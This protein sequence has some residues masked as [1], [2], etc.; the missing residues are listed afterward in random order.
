MSAGICIGF[1]FGIPRA[2]TVEDEDGKRRYGVNTNLEQI[3]DWLTKIIVGVSLIQLRA[4]PGYVSR[5][6]QRLGPSFGGD[7]GFVLSILVGYSVCG[8]LVGYLLT[9]LYM[10]GALSRADQTLR[11]I[12]REVAR[13]G[14]ATAEKDTAGTTDPAV[15][16]VSPDQESAAIE[17]GR[18]ALVADTQ[19]L[20]DQVA[21]LAREYE[22]IR[23][24]Y[25]SGTERTRMMSVVASKMRALS[26]ACY[27][28][29]PALARSRKP[30]ERLAA[31]SFLEVKPSEELVPWLAERIEQ[32]KPFVGYHSAW[33]LRHAA[34]KLPLSALPPVAEAIRRG[35]AYLREHDPAAGDRIATLEAALR[36]LEQ[37]QAEA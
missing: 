31:V 17:V 11:Q 3:S 22:A 20:R 34:R 33:A 27:S 25:P 12:G 36:E 21:A 18:L 26:L 13:V 24:A 8:F 1:L 5:L 19:A 29:L 23:A 28:L 7:L 35:L 10:A 30:G 37:R 9:R 32:E 14:R 15:D 2:P 16:P 4:V 6:L